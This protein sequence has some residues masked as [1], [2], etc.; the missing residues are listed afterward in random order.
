MSVAI[1]L[2]RIDAEMQH[3]HQILKVPTPRIWVDVAKSDLIALLQDH[4][5][6]ERKAAATAISLIS[7]YPEDTDLL[8]AMA[9]LAQ[10]ELRHFQQ[11]VDLLHARGAMLG[12]DRGDPYVVALM[13]LRRQG[14][15]SARKID[16]LL[17]VGI[18]EARSWERLFLLG[19]YL[20]DPSLRTFYSRLA[21]AEAGHYRLFVRLACKEASPEIIAA[22]L[23]E[24]LLTEGEIMMQQGITARVH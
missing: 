4:A 10:E 24:L 14:H 20:E 15:P 5:H 2:E 1:S 9:R 8:L 6:C 7:S 19:E 17:I 3:P 16:W 13:K 18:V 21:R 23:D 11:V 22:R 12:S